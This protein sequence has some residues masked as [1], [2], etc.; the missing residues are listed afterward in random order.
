MRGFGGDSMKYRTAAF[1]NHKQIKINGADYIEY[2][3]EKGKVAEFQ[4]PIDLAGDARY[5][6]FYTITTPVGKDYLKPNAYPVKSEST[7]LVNNNVAADPN[8]K[9]LGVQASEPQAEP[10][11]ISDNGE[12]TPAPQTDIPSSPKTDTPSAPPTVVD[13][14]G[15]IV[16]LKD[17]AIGAY[18]VTK[19]SVKRQF[20]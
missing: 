4:I 1:V 11:V 18:Y 2:T 6:T 7:L 5:S 12:P 13:T 17:D 15:T 10:P 8:E 20:L 19:E 3:I 9:P 14:S 16:T